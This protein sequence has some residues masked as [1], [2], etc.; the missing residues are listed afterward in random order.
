MQEADDELNQ[1]YKSNAG[2]IDAVAELKV[3][4]ITTFCWSCLHAPQCTTKHSF[5]HHQPG[6]FSLQQVRVE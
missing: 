6:C 2:L 1:L 4:V 3:Q 5:T